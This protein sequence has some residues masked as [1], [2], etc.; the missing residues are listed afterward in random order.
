MELLRLDELPW[1]ALAFWVGA[2]WLRLLVI[3]GSL[4]IFFLSSNDPIKPILSISK[5]MLLPLKPLAYTNVDIA[6]SCGKSSILIKQN[7]IQIASFLR[8]WRTDPNS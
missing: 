4:C 3:V 7:P 8:V 6:Q 2:A 5:Y 1:L